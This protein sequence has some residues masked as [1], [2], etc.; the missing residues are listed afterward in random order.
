MERVAMGG[1]RIVRAFMGGAAVASGLFG[2]A[3]LFYYWDP[4]RILWKRC[5]AP[6]STTSTPPGPRARWRLEWDGV[7]F[8]PEGG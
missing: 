4:T 8:H 7:L 6:A 1:W 3:S 2:A 5:M